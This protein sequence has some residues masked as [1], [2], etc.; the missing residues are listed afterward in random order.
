MTRLTAAVLAVATLAAGAASAQGYY[1]D[2]YYGDG[3][4]DTRYRDDRGDDYDDGYG[5]VDYAQV[6][7]VRPIIVGGR[8]PGYGQQCW[9]EP[10]RGHYTAGYGG[11]GYDGTDYGY[12]GYDDDHG[13]ARDDGYRHRGSSAAPV[14]GAIIGGVI[15]NQFGHNRGRDAAT[16]AGAALGYALARDSQRR[17]YGD[18]YAYGQPASVQRCRTVASYRDDERVEGY[19]VTYQYNGRTYHTTT[20]YHPGDRIRVR[21]DVRPES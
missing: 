17:Y 18:G 7:D 1:G 13:Y 14:L 20:P 8:E 10:A 6:L 9:Q 21:V 16:L 5:Q 2:S 11:A 3:R 12:G 4:Y 19:D 15:G